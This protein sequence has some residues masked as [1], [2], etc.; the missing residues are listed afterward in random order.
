MNKIVLVLIAIVVI[1]VVVFILYEVLKP[2]SESFGWRSD[3]ATMNKIN[4]LA[5]KLDYECRSCNRHNNVTCYKCRHII[6]KI[7][8]L[9]SQL[10]DPRNLGKVHR[11]MNII[12]NT[13]KYLANKP[14]YVPDFIHPS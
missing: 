10:N 12:N 1:I 13:L 2:S 4:N 11:R 3:S 14:E 6:S 8:K 9:M 7:N 5:K